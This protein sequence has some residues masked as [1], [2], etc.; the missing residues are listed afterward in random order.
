MRRITT[1]I[2]GALLAT[3]IAL[4]ASAAPAG[5]QGR[6]GN[7]VA[8]GLK[9]LNA[10]NLTSTVARDGLPVELGFGNLSLADTIQ[11]HL[12]APQLFTWCG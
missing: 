4:P 11:V 12:D 3:A 8:N 7:C 5:S 9:T 6:D 10:L 1:I 2:G